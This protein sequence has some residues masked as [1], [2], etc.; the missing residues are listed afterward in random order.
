METKL[1]L[2]KHRTDIFNVLFGNKVSPAAARALYSHLRR[3]EQNNG[4][5]Y[6][7][8][9]LKLRFQALLKPDISPFRTHRDGTWVGPFRPLSTLS[10]RGRSGFLSAL[11]VLKLYGLFRAPEPGLDEYLSSVK[12]ISTQ[13]E[14]VDYFMYRLPKSTLYQ[15]ESLKKIGFTCQYPLST[16]LVPLS[17]E[18]KRA[19]ILVSHEEHLKSLDNC[20]GLLV[21]YYDFFKPLVGESLPPI[22]YYM[23]LM[24]RESYE[25]DVVGSYT[26]LT[27]DRG[28]KQRAVVNA[29]RILQLACSRLSN[30]L[31]TYLKN[32]PECYI[33][34]QEGGAT[35]VHRK[36]TQ[37]CVL[38]SVDLDSATDNIPMLPQLTL[39]ATMFP[40]LKEDLKVFG[41]ISR[42][43]WWTPYEKLY[44][45]YTRGHGMGLNG[46]FPLFTVWLL[47]LYRS[48]GAKDAFAIVGDDL[49]IESKYEESVLKILSKHGVPV[50]Y[51]KSL[52][53]HTIAEFVG[54]IIDKHGDGKVYKA[55]P[56]DIQNDP[57][58]LIRQY[59]LKAVDRTSL[60]KRGKSFRERLVL[61]QELG[62]NLRAR[63]LLALYLRKPRQVE[64][65]TGRKAPNYKE[66]GVPE[67]L[68]SK[69]LND[70]TDP[71]MI[72]AYRK[73]LKKNPRMNTTVAMSLVGSELLHHNVVSWKFQY[74]PP[75]LVEYVNAEI[76]AFREANPHHEWGEKANLPTTELFET[77]LT[78]GLTDLK[79]VERQAKDAVLLSK[80]KREREAL[81]KGRVNLRY[82]FRFTN[83]VKTASTAIAAWMIL[84]K[85][86]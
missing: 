70:G 23:E 2:D 58:G 3:I 49:V 71:D 11:R 12:G 60:K 51:S 42:G 38:S 35:W 81:R 80:A 15:C 79:E 31:F 27:K 54:R 73:L 47:Q 34:D 28:L 9:I 67:H 65:M 17:F 26:I 25:G 74:N 36:L 66:G 86:K 18:Q 61:F 75:G 44:A 53:N 77:A 41:Q 69:M 13:P 62:D 32:Q 72:A 29:F 22:E 24:A 52:F 39:A 20:P 85:G 6:L 33:F 7:V 10:K 21:S 1:Y 14:S 63:R 5:K 83:A 78:P 82:V 56:L 68:L 40:W 8:K 46:S 55:S 4:A 45:S 43:K 76:Q 57:L 30:T 50:N 37:G 48:V 59:G 19:E 64:L 84:L 16:T